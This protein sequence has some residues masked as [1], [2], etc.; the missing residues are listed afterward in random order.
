[1]IY[2]VKIEFKDYPNGNWEDWSEYLTSVFPIS[3]KVESEVRGEAGVI[4]FDNGSLE[5]YYTHGNP[6]YNAFD[7]ELS[8][9]QRYLFR[10]SYYSSNS[11]YI[12]LYEGMCDFSSIKFPHH[13]KTIVFDVVDKLTALGILNS[14]TVR[15]VISTFAEFA[16][17]TNS[18]YYVRPDWDTEYDIEI[19]RLDQTGNM[20]D[21]QDVP[22]QLGEVIEYKDDR[23]F[24]VKEENITSINGPDGFPVK[25]AKIKALFSNEKPNE[26]NYPSYNITNRNVLTKTLY[27]TDCLIYSSGIPTD[28]DMLPFISS[29]IKSQWPEIDIVNLSGASTFP[30]PLDYFAKLINEQ[31]FGSNP[32]EALKSIAD[33][34]K[35]YIYINRFGNLVIQSKDAL[36]TNGTTRTLGNTRIISGETNYFYDK[37]V[38]G[39]EVKVNSWVV[40]DESGDYLQGYSI[41]TKSAPGSNAY[42]KPKNLLSREVIVNDASKN[43]KEELDLYA[44]NFAQSEMNFYGKRHGSISFVLDLNDSTLNWE[45]VDNIS[46]NDVIYFFTSIGLDLVTEEVEIEFV[47]VNGED[48]DYRQVLIGLGENN[49]SS[50]TSGG[51]SSGGSGTT[52]I[53]G[54]LNSASEQ[55]EITSDGTSSITIQGQNAPKSI[56]FVQVYKNGMMLRN[57]ID[58][59]LSGKTI[60][61][62]TGRDYFY[63]VDDVFVKYFY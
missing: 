2:K 13:S 58:F 33:T 40:D 11:V 37:I 24:F 8:N 62:T 38:D 6:V 36:A 30:V 60:T 7:I 31:P 42:V 41:L 5:F 1:M 32:L 55:I 23:Y 59:T 19:Y 17:D 14:N 22:F 54:S 16:G 50:I 61:L 45:L 49:S 47:E 10:I 34:M 53:D 56:E 25:V 48:Y 44:Y 43:T 57:G 26:W 63:K 52:I 51:S 18:L 12:P 9:K 39:V 21:I 3:R 28:Y 20:I 27:G 15:T 29:L 4:T 35:C 46:Y